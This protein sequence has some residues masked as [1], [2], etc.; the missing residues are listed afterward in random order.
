MSRVVPGPSTSLLLAAYSQ[1]LFPMD[2]EGSASEPV[3]F[4]VAEQRAVLPIDGFRVPRSVARGLRRIDYEIR[5]DTA[6]NEVTAACAYGRDVWLSPRLADSYVDLHRAGYA[7]SVEAWFAG[8]LVGGL[9]GAALGGL[10]TSESMFHLTPDAG[11][12]ALVATAGLLAAG[13]FTLWDIQMATDH[14][15]R[16]GAEELSRAEYDRRLAHAL[17][18]RARLRP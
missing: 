1:G 2:G 8:R 7:H 15:R 17:E 14:T 12:A 13:G 5:V 4:Y 6:F 18:V 9:F 3:P 16:F 10:F 11:N